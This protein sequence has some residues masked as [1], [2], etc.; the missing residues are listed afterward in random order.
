MAENIRTL[1]A[2]KKVELQRPPWLYR[3]IKR[4][5]SNSDSGITKLKKES[6]T[7]L[8]KFKKN[9]STIL[10]LNDVKKRQSS[11]RKV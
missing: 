4:Q 1:L 9:P 11:R 3:N 5:S 10:K 7:S 6:S 8:I 2:L